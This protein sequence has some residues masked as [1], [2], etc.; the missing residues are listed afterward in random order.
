MTNCETV[1]IWKGEVVVAMSR[2]AP[3]EPLIQ[4]IPEGYFPEDKSAEA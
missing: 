2:P 3:S 1:R 4:W